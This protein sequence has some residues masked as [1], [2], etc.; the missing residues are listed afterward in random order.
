MTEAGQPEKLTPADSEARLAV[1]QGWRMEAQ[2][3]AIVKDFRF[4]DFSAAFG[5]MARVALLAEK[6]NHHPEW[7]N[8]YNRV[9]VRLTTHDAEGLSKLDFELAAAMDS[10]I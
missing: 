5:F 9:H 2:G 8:I 7:S 6:M 3:D 10:L 1:L 4:T